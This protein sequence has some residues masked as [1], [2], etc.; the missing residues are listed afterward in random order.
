MDLKIVV[1]LPAVSDKLFD[2]D[3]ANEKEVPTP[4]ENPEVEKINQEARAEY[5][6]NHPTISEFI[7]ELKE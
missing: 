5:H 6:L 3:I 7:K 4:E 2:S 1:P